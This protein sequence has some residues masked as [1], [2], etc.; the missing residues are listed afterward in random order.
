MEKLIWKTGFRLEK[1]V[2]PGDEPYEILEG[3][4]NCALEEGMDEIWQLVIGGS[5]S[6]YDNSGALMAVGNGTQAA[7]ATQTALQGASM[8]T[9][10][11]VTD[12]PTTKGETAKI[13]FKGEFATTEANF[14]WTEWSVQHT[15]DINLNRKVEALGTKSGGTW[16]LEIYLELQNV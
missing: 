8:A 14:V 1:R 13:Y 5:A 16:S 3:E 2:N 15:D 12:Y 7:N 10:A 9:A 4:G 11:M 6:H